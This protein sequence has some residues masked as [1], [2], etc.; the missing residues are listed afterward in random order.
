MFFSLTLTL[1]FFLFLDLS[2]SL[3]LRLFNTKIYTHF[4]RWN[5]MRA[6]FLLLRRFFFFTIIHYSDIIH[7]LDLSTNNLYSSEKLSRK[8]LKWSCNWIDDECD[9]I[10]EN[11]IVRRIFSLS[12][13][14][15][16]FFFHWNRNISFA[17]FF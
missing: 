1:L 11:T 13:V 5:R 4:T 7:E 10:T 17:S 12:L 3:D 14:S 16:F 9:T 2:L 6:A 8:K 15:N